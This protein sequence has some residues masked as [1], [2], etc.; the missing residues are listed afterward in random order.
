[1]YNVPWGLTKSDPKYSFKVMGKQVVIPASACFNRPP[2]EGPGTTPP[3][4]S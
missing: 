3:F 4:K 2:F 1:M